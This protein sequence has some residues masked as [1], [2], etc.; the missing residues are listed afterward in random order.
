[1]KRHAAVATLLLGTATVLALTARLV[2]APAETPQARVDAAWTAM[3]GDKLAALKTITLRAHLLQWD[4]GESY[5]VSDP[6][7]PGVRDALNDIKTAATD[8]ITKADA[9]LGRL[10]GV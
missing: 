4:P 5:S 3:G 7:K 1:M 2:A 6:D 10:G 8:A 9:L